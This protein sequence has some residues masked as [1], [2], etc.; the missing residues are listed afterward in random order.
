[1]YNNLLKELGDK[2]LKPIQNGDKVRFVYLKMPNPIKDTVIAAPD[3]LPEGVELDKYIDKDMQFNKSFLEPIRS[4]TN[5]IGWDVE[6]T[7]TLEDFFS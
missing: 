3:E 1:M 4:I 2:R 6:H 7:T 5:V